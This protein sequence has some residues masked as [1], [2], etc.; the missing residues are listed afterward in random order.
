MRFP[1]EFRFIL[2]LKE[3]DIPKDGKK[4]TVIIRTTGKQQYSPD[5]IYELTVRDGEVEFPK[6][7]EDVTKARS[8]VCVRIE[9][10]DGAFLGP[11]ISENKGVFTIIGYGIYNDDQILELGTVR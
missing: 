8:L 9:N 5:Q 7:F 2:K 11:G 6:W 3:A 4:L 1:G 10:E